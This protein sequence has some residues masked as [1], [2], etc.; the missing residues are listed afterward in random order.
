MISQSEERRRMISQYDWILLHP[1]TAGELEIKY[2][3]E[4]AMT[5][6]DNHHFYGCTSF[7][8]II[9]GLNRWFALRQRAKSDASEPGNAKREAGTDT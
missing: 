1:P 6:H 8:V 5:F 9:I 7:F 2:L 3:R 4:A